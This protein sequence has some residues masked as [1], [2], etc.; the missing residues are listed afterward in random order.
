MAFDRDFYESLAEF[1]YALRQ[2]LAFSEAETHSAG[3]TAQQYQALLIIKTHPDG[4]VMIREL[5]A[6][7]L[8]QHH[9]AV[10]LID[11]LVAARLVARR[12]SVTDRRV[13]RVAMTPRGEKLLQRLASNH[14]TELLK[15]EPLLADSLKRLRKLSGGPGKTRAARRTS[16]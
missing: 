3:I 4:M 1:R 16:A 13:V 14:L 10:Q 6:K 12:P 5:A 8:L 2:F 7:M 11:R 15:H 9:G